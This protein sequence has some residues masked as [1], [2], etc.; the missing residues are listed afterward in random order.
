MEELNGDEK[1]IETVPEHPVPTE[2]MKNRVLGH[3]LQLSYNN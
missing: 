2:K 1:A 3:S